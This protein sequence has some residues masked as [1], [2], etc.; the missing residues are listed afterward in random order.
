MDD[1]WYMCTSCSVQLLLVLSCGVSFSDLSERLIFTEEISFGRT[2]EFLQWNS[3]DSLG[4]C[5]GAQ[6]HVREH[7]FIF[8]LCRI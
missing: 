8:C 4:Q 3:G 6:K 5:Q 1:L 7:V 2:E